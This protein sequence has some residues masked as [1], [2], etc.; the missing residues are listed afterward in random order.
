M[1]E[2]SII[3]PVYNGE[4]YLRE[5]IE[6]VLK[7]DFNNFELIIVNDCST[8][9]SL[10]IAEEYAQKDSRINIINNIKNE[11]L[12]RAL[13][14][15]FRNAKGKYFTWTSDDNMYTSDAIRTMYSFLD[16]NKNYGLVYCGMH[17]INEDGEIIGGMSKKET[18]LYYRDCVGA[19][20]MYRSEVLH[21]VGEYNQQ[22]FLVEDYDYWIRISEKYPIYHIDEYKYYYRFHTESLT[23]TRADKINEQLYNLRKEKLN[24]MLEKMNEDEK[25]YLFIDMWA[26]CNDETLIKTFFNKNYLPDDLK[27]MRRE[28][29]VDKNKKYILFGAGDFGKKA[30]EFLGKERIE[31]FVDNNTEKVGTYIDDIKVIS[32]FEMTKIYEKY[33]ILITVD[34]RKSSILANQLIDNNIEIFETYMELTNNLKKPSMNNI[35][36]IESFNKA[37]N[38]IEKNTINNK[39]IINNTKLIKPYPEVTGYYIPTL[40]KWGYRDLAVS[41]AKWLCSIQKKDGS[42]YDTEDK[43]PY[44]FDS[45]QILKGLLAV[46]EILPEVDQNIKRGCE[47]IINNMNESGRLTTPSKDLWD[48][49]ECSE[50]I[51]LYCLSPLI[52]AGNVFKIK[53]YKNCAKKVAEYYIKN[54]KEDILDFNILS[55]FYAYIME[56]LCDIG[57]EDIARE[58]MIKVADFQREDGMVPA[59]KDVNWVCSTGL[60]QFA[61]V[62][63]KLGDLERGNKAV[64]YAVSLQ[65]E[66][67]GW[68]G[69]YPLIDNPRSIDKKEYPNYFETSEI[70]WAVKYFLDAVYYKNKLEFENQSSLFFESIDKNDGR[71][72]IIFNELVKSK[73]RKVCDVGCGKGRYIKNLKKD[74]ENIDIYAV[75]L[76]EKVMSKIKDAK[77]KKQGSLTCIPYEDDTFD[78]TYSIE[79]LEYAVAIEN[80]VKEM[81]RVTKN[82]GKVIIIDK[83]KSAMGLLEVDEW[84]QWFEDE[85]FE[86]IASQT[87]CTLEIIQNIK[88]DNDL[89]DNLFNCWIFT[90]CEDK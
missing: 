71:Y 66:S 23:G 14:I 74:I 44:V 24:F 6:S 46:R 65:N 58:A 36:W 59:Y 22:K 20:F 53:K 54:F 80:A 52:E 55:H 73:A 47:W 49:N 32:F 7:Q 57:M 33:N 37:M 28:K 43:S 84:E 82:N 48:E 45:G 51:H 29:N 90:K 63:Y 42:W 87:N 4:K 13:N 21:T 76:S 27:W 31:F 86:E 64:S 10:I 12:P 83:N 9:N 72:K 3:M 88:Y 67:G 40:M 17:F 85:F 30:V 41:Y 70:S 89:N 5:S 69:S 79:A 25:K 19:C 75:D 81:I 56:A 68:Y 34:S 26:Q 18:E 1:V 11:K 15:G 78:V 2:V 16:N 61:I 62:W 50:L 60:F 77:E 35:N 8:D 39:G 38:W